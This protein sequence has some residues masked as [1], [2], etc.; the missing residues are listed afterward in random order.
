MSEHLV[1]HLLLSLDERR[2]PLAVALPELSALRA[3]PAATLARG[4]LVIASAPFLGSV[5]L[6]AIV[7]DILFFCLSASLVSAIW[8]ALG[9][10]ELLGQAQVIVLFG[11]V[12]FLFSISLVL[13]LLL[14]LYLLRGQ[15]IVL[16]RS[17]VEFTGRRAIVFCPWTIFL[18]SRE[19]EQRH[20]K[21]ILIPVVAERI[22]EVELRRRDGNIVVGTE[23]ATSIIRFNRR[24]QLVLA[25]RFAAEG[26]EIG[27]LLI[28][29]A[30]MLAG[31]ETCPDR[32]G[33]R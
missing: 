15:Q 7:L 5:I 6:V 25:N 29:V 13:G 24:G 22:P 4:P 23:V 32:P 12:V 1:A 27:R 28:D 14:A 26:T 10:R 31:N 16:R 18:T 21:S 11:T 9:I 20:A 33:L 3:D 17:G 19:V 30:C 8:D 2:Q